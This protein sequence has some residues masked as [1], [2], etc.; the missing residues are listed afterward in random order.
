MTERSLLWL[1][2]GIV[3]TGCNAANSAPKENGAKI[4]LTR[5]R[6][7][8]ESSARGESERA[9]EQAGVA[10][11]KDP[12]LADA[13]YIRGRELLLVGRIREAVADLD[14]YV[15]LRPDEEVRQWERGIAYYY[16]RQYAEGARQFALYQTYDDGDVENAVW[17][18]LCLA[19]HEG[20]A[21]A[22]RQLMPIDQDPRV[23]LM[24]VYGVFQGRTQ[25]DDV[26]AA[27]RAGDP[28]PEIL[29]A[30]LFYAHLYL[31]LYY[32]ALNQSERTCAH[33]AEATRPLPEKAPASRYMWR[34]A[35]VHAQQLE[36]QK[37]VRSKTARQEPSAAAEPDAET[38]DASPAEN[39]DQ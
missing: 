19:R 38:P 23:P 5:L 15:S 4:A 30:R 6:E 25:P 10:I 11:E 24:E 32:D 35:K 2:A 12:Q 33:L 9:I 28:A 3:L 34:V 27:A 13:Y 37:P 14:R 39:G 1:L 36:A 20:L 29:A 17:H 31:A 16:N 7:A 21:A 18:F 8:Y 26:L 22:R